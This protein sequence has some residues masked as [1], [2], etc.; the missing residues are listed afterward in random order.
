MSK[1][2]RD[3]AVY[4]AEFFLRDALDVAG[5]GD[6]TFELRGMHLTMPTEYKF[7]EL[8]HIQRYVNAVIKDYNLSTGSNHKPVWVVEGRAN[9]RKKAYYK[10]GQGEIVLP[11]RD[12]GS[13]AWRQVVVLH[14]VAH[15]LTSGH[16]HDE[17]F[18]SCLAHLLEEHIGP[19]AGLVY[20]VMLDK[21]NIKIKEKQHV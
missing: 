15:H 13:W 2:Y 16:G 8:D 4:G 18:A 10:T 21:N 9:L 7:G 12:K 1:T 6:G 14:E 3:N 5:E 17:V 11:K 20:R 19:E